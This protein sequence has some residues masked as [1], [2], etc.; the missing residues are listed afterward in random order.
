MP[1][2]TTEASGASSQAPVNFAAGAGA[3]VPAAASAAEASTAT[4]VNFAGVDDQAED[5][6][7]R[8][9]SM[10]FV[11]GLCFFEE[12]GV[13]LRDF[14][15]VKREEV[16]DIHTKLDRIKK[17]HPDDYKTL[18]DYKALK[19]QAKNRLIEL[20]LHSIGIVFDYH[21]AAIKLISWAI[22]LGQAEAKTF[23][24]EY[25]QRANVPS[26][27]P[28]IYPQRQASAFAEREAKKRLESMH[29]ASGGKVLAVVVDPLDDQANWRAGCHFFA[30]QLKAMDK[31][32]AHYGDR[33]PTQ[34]EAARATPGL[35][36]GCDFFCIARE[37]PKSE[38]SRVA[39]ELETKGGANL[40]ARGQRMALDE[41]MAQAQC[42]G[43]EYQFSARDLFRSSR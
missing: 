43:E 16:A 27:N 30:K 41:R 24:D 17:Q 32:E 23:L 39:D 3:A 7:E 21:C 26:D 31:R 1:L 6:P 14:K 42:K 13:K 38:L 4:R 18:A 25:D 37:D 9:A 8:M 28:K 5:T 12:M 20:S 10:L 2:N 15:H 40:M 29:E 22:R 36:D 35:L 19:K 33:P 34:A 11:T